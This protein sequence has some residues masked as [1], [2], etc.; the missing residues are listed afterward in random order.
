MSTKNQKCIRK[1]KMFALK[2]TDAVTD[3]D[4]RN[5]QNV[6]VTNDVKRAATYA[7]TDFDALRKDVIRRFPKT[8][9]RL[10]E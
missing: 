9:A 1:Q 6:R 5:D 2:K 8:L 7:C 4:I 3:K 10:A